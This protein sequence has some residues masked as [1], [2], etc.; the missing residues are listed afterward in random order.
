MFMW[1]IIVCFWKEF[2]ANILCVRFY[3]VDSERVKNLALKNAQDAYDKHQEKVWHLLVHTGSGYW[4]HIIVF[5]NDWFVYFSQRQLFDQEGLSL[6]N[7]SISTDAERPQPSMF[8]GT[9]KAYQLKV[10]IP[11]YFRVLIHLKIINHP[12]IYW[13]I[14]L[15]K[16]YSKLR[17]SRWELSCTYMVIYVCI[18]FNWWIS[19]WNKSWTV[20]ND[21]NYSFLFHLIILLYCW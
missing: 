18:I 19:V 17:L 4:Q 3:I 2:R 16:I 6:A 10:K 7:P 14:Q 21:F 13:S 8:E 20:Y 15:L 5:C 11:S 12:V 1:I 9:L